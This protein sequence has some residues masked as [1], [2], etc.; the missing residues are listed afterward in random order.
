MV[1]ST[2]KELREKEKKFK[3]EISGEWYCFSK[4]VIEGASEESI[5]KPLSEG[6]TTI[7]TFA[8]LSDRSQGI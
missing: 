4:C 8:T 5:N 1:Q 6:D 7:E 2:E 3:T